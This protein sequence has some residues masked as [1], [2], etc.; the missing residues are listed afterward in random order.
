M[1]TPSLFFLFFFHAQCD[2]S[3]ICTVPILSSA[4]A[5][6][7]AAAGAVEPRLQ[8]ALSLSHQ[9]IAPGHPARVLGHPVLPALFP[10]PHAR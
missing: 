2:T 5:A 4:E 10:R 6:A 7:L 1:P 8:T 9:T 3:L